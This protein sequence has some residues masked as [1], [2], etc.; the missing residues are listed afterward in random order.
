ME[1]PLS[2]SRTPSAAPACDHSPQR[3]FDACTRHTAALLVEHST[4]LLLSIVVATFVVALPCEASLGAIRS[5]VNHAAI[6]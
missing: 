3:A 6:R 5:H 2:T 4:P 1:E